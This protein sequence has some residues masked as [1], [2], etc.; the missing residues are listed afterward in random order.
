MFE[1]LVIE[2]ALIV[3]LGLLFMVVVAVK[4]V[5]LFFGQDDWEN[6]YLTGLNDGAKYERTQNEK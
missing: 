6:G 5:R 4:D 3:L 1:L 2:I